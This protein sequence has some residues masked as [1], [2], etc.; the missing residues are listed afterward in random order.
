MLVTS[1]HDS[2]FFT[3]NGPMRTSPS[4]F[5][6]TLNESMAARMIRR[7][8]RNS[9]SCDRLVE[10]RLNGIATEARI[11]TI[12]NVTRSSRSVTPSSLTAPS[13]CLSPR[14][15]HQRPPLRLYAP[16]QH[17]WERHRAPSL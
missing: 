7:C 8:C 5:H 13:Q 14:V 15:T 3:H 10:T 12:V 6:S 9:I 16:E 2:L 11:I 1:L 17:E 4:R